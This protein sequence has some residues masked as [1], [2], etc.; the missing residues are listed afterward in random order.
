MSIQFVYI[1]DLIVF[2]YFSLKYEQNI[3]SF[4]KRLA[5]IY[6]DNHDGF[7]F[8]AGD[9]LS[10]KRFISDENC[11]GSVWNNKRMDGAENKNY[12]LRF[13][14]TMYGI[15]GNDNIIIKMMPMEIKRK[16]MITKYKIL[17]MIIFALELIHLIHF[18]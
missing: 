8:N 12:Q 1:S 17:F 6:Y 9:G 15:D 18:I 16:R 5:Q 2:G 10:N 3:P 11:V 7:E 14:F 4:L 13:R